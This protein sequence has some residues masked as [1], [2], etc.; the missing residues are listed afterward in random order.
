MVFTINVGL[1]NNPKTAEETIQYLRELNGYY[2]VRFKVSSGS[3]HDIIEPTV[4]AELTTEYKLLSKVIADFENICSVLGQECIGISSDEFDL[5]VHGIN[6]QGFKD[7][8]DE[9]YFLTI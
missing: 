2:L 9:D 8:F 4:V 5:L 3:Y 7:K 1:I 6:F